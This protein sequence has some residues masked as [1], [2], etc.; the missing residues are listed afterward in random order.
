VFFH[1]FGADSI[2]LRLLYWV[3]KQVIG[4]A[5]RVP[6]ELRLSIYNA[7]SAAGISLAFPQRDIH[8]ATATPISVQVLPPAAH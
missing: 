8:L 5:N 6:S 3:D 7:L 1:D 4:T 2:V